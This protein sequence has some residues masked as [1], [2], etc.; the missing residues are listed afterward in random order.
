MKLGGSLLLSGHLRKWLSIIVQHGKV[1]VVLV[2][3]GGIFADQVRTAQQRWQ[4]DDHSA[5][6]MALLAMEQYAYLLQS[7]EPNLYLADS[8]PKIKKA[9]QK[10]KVSIWLPSKMISTSKALS[11]NWNLS[12]DSL[13]LWLACHVRTKH[14]MLIK[15]LAVN[16]LN[17][18][19][20]SGSGI[21]DK[22]F[23]SFVKKSKAAIWWLAK[24]DMESLENLLKENG[25]PKDYLS[26][27]VY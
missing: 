17:S 11:T 23:P 2:P 24:S 3:G 18:R 25:K 10:N 4:F 5:H 6:Q 1:K 9:M 22:D 13:A 21:V 16:N 20:L 26:S 15:S 8:I 14:I 27:V 12:S 19:Q 7:Y